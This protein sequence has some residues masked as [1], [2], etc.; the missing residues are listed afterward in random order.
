MKQKNLVLMVVAVGCGLVAAFLTSQMSAKPTVEKV[1]VIVAAKDLVVGSHLTKDD[2]S[3]ALKR[4]VVAKDAV[5][6]NIIESEEEMLDKR[7]TRT[8]R[9]DETI[10]KADLAK[11][12]TIT[13]P[14]G[15]SMVTLPIS[16]SSAVAGFV[17]PG[18]HVD[19]LGSVRLNTTIR[20]L[21][22][23]VNMLVL[24]V[25]ANVALPEK[26]GPYQ[27]VSM[28]S[29]AVD[30]KQALLFKLAQARGCD[31]SL[32]LRRTEDTETENDKAY[33]IEEVTKLLQD[34]TR[35][36]LKDPKND[37]NYGDEEDPKPKEVAKAETVKVPA[38]IDDIAAGTQ[39]TSDLIAEKFKVIELPK[40]LAADAVTDLAALAT[41]K[42][43]LRT[44]LGKGQWVTKSLVGSAVPKVA[45]R[46]EF[47]IPK[48]GPTDPKPPIKTVEGRA[49]R[50]VAIHSASG[51][52]VYRYEEVAP[53]EW[54]ITRSWRLG[55]KPPEQK[56]DADKP[57]DKPAE[58]E[59]PKEAT[60]D[61]E[62]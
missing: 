43:V 32:L 4:K 11:G 19:V 62:I 55:E 46:D 26:G 51:S 27:T 39:I 53:G 35:V 20:V 28:V 3:K 2:L 34:R 44:G 17:G 12:G 41:E 47:A 6:P 23:L 56:A 16:L 13:I 50:E 14:P 38:A 21:P 58:K 5:P 8:I 15:K 25:D 31:L 59:K 60:P 52:R 24:A 57:E 10:N 7:F 48:P 29:F 42:Q 49:V 61:R 18:S 30:R 33:K 40:D 54:R 45:P 22:I 1:E 37:S 9:V 36:D